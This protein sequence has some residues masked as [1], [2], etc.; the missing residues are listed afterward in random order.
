MTDDERRGWLAG[1]R[2][3]DRIAIRPYGQEDYRQGGTLGRRHRPYDWRPDEPFWDV[4]PDPGEHLPDILEMHVWESELEPLPYPGMTGLAYVGPPPEEWR[5]R[6]RQRLKAARRLTP[7][8][9]AS[10][11]RTPG[12]PAPRRTSRGR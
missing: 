3:G 9:T 11:A 10:S 12:D 7:T 1:L 5:R 2:P 6:A 4:A 8:G